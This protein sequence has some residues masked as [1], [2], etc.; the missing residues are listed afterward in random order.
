[1]FGGEILAFLSVGGVFAQQG[2]LFGDAEVF[3]AFFGVDADN[4]LEVLDDLHDVL[5]E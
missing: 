3:A 1:M 5:A 4:G 2:F